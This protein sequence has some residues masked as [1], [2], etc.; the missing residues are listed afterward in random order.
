MELSWKEPICVAR[1]KTH[2]DETHSTSRRDLQKAFHLADHK[3][4]RLNRAFTVRKMR[5]KRIVEMK[6]QLDTAVGQ[7]SFRERIVKR[8]IAFHRP[9]THYERRERRADRIFT[10]A[11]PT[12]CI[13]DLIAFAR[14]D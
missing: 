13:V 4:P 9:N 14:L 2:G 1:G 3:A 11:R 7:N 5:S 10:I 12:H 6:D 8:A